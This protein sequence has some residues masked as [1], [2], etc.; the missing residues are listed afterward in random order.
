MDTRQKNILQGIKN[1]DERLANAYA[2]FEELIEKGNKK[3]FLRSDDVSLDR[4]VSLK[5]IC[6]YMGID[7]PSFDP[8]SQN[9]EAYI[10]EVLRKNGVLSR[11]CVLPEKW[12]K[13]AVCVYLAELKEGR[14][15]ALMPDSW[16]RYYYHDLET[17]KRIFVSRHNAGRI[18]ENAFMYYI[19]LP[20]DVLGAKELF[21]FMRRTVKAGDGILAAAAALLIVLI[22]LILPIATSLMLSFVIPEKNAGMIASL[23][24]FLLSSVIARY[25]ISVSQ[26]LTVSRITQRMTIY[27]E[28]A[29]FARTLDLPVDFFRKHRTGDIYGALTYVEPLCT[30][31]CNIWFS[32]GPMLIFSALYLFQIRNAVPSMQ[33]PAI[34]ILGI[35]LLLQILGIIGQKKNVRDKLDRQVATNSLAL[36][37]LS[38]IEQIK[39]CGAKKR[40]LSRYAEV[41]KLQ[42][43]AEYNPPLVVKLQ[44]ALLPA[45]NIFGMGILFYYAQRANI[46]NAQ[47][48]YFFTSFGLANAAVSALS[49]L[50]SQIASIDPILELLKPILEE[51][52]EITNVGQD[53]GTLSGRI[54]AEHLEFR[55]ESDAPPVLKDFTLSVEKGEYIAVVGSSGSGKTTF[56]RLLLGFDTPESGA[57]YYDGN[58][59]RHLDL[60]LLRQQIG[61]VLQDGKLFTGNIFTNIAI[62]SPGLTEEE[63]WQAAEMAGIADDI[64][65]MPLGMYTIVSDGAGT[66]SGGQKQRLLIA[67]VIAQKPSILILDEATSALDNITQ[68]KVT[69]ALAS[70][71]CT[72]IVIAHRLSTVRECDRIVVLDG[73]H[74][75]EEGTYEELMNKNGSFAELVRHQL[76]EDAG[77]GER[78]NDKLPSPI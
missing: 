10:K 26:N 59:L 20:Q 36:D 23:A 19:P 71:K 74:I 7:A 41:Y 2:A 25:F 8:Y 54:S 69:D 3:N 70:L 15:V 37:L 31:W 38:G 58:N 68:K 48:I 46:S 14:V 1:D 75:T 33:I 57:I 72:R 17:G 27:L 21:R 5:H 6:D 32:S 62:S 40:T 12:Y 24:A 44:K 61:V 67:R 35:E 30:T 42:S 63:A 56:T 34:C 16:G 22:G 55:Y 66:L 65:A 73:G 43:D 13:N 45:V 77:P 11:P 76:I 28:S 64:R 60:A 50:G 52:P 49:G 78:P 18:K 4:P 9:S 29:L 51:K 39:V 53:P 47:F